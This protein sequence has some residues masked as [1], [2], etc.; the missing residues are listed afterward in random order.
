MH[1][2]SVVSCLFFITTDAGYLKKKITSN[3]MESYIFDGKNL[4][5]M[6]LCT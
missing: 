4:I 6:N 2:I 3:A 1:V 5:P